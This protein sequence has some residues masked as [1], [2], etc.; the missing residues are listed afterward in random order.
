DLEL[1]QQQMLKLQQNI[2][3]NTTTDAAERLQTLQTE[4]THLIQDTADIL[5]QLTDKE[6]GL[7]KLGEEFVLNSQLLDGLESRLKELISNIST[8]AKYLSGCV[9]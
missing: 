1:L 7:Q 9:A 3:I 8:K 2:D 6:A 4:A 5:N